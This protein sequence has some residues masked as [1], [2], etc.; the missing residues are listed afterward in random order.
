[1]ENLAAKNDKPL[2]IYDGDCGFCW[3]WASYWQKLTGD[4]VSYKPYQEVASQYPSISIKEFQQAVQYVAPDGSIASA[5]KASFLTL[6]NAPGQ[7]LWL[8]LYRKLPGFAPLTEWAYHFISTRRSFFHK[9]SIGLW[10]KTLEPAKYDMVAWIF[11]RLFGLLFLAA[12]LSFG[13]QAMALIG[14]RGIIPVAEMMKIIYQQV[15]AL[16]YWYVPVVFWLNTSDFFIQAVCWGGVVFSL[17]LI[18]NILPRAS[19]FFLYVLYLSLSYAGQVFMSFQWDMF[20]VE[21]A[22]VAIF[23]VG[24]TRLTGIMLMRWLLFR[25]I[26]AAGLVKILSGDP[27]WRNLTSLTY[28]FNTAPLPTPLAWYAHHLPVPVL[29]F[30]AFSAL[31]VELVI[32]FLIFLPRYPRFVGAFAILFMQTLISLTGNYN[33]FNLQTMLLC[34][35]LFDDQALSACLPQRFSHWLQPRA[36]CKA[37]NKWINGFA[38]V[39]AIYLIFISVVQFYQRFSGRQVPLPVAVAAGALEQ[40]RLVSVYGPFAVMTQDRMEIIFEGSA[41]GVYWAEYKFKYKPGDVDKRPPINIPHQPRVDWQMWFAA[42]GTVNQ[43][44]W[45]VRFMERILEGSPPVVDLLEYNPFPDK[46]PLL[47]RAEFYRYRFTTPEERK[48][49]GA[50]WH[51]EYVQEYV[52]AIHLLH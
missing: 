19:L 46:P 13:V 2:L 41:D 30:M 5:A 42:L 51:R 49:T 27:T 26:F 39:I 18:L 33:F 11:L 17:L 24:S 43:N 15:G 37:P 14:S 32:P 35:V 48:Q 21:A 29:K 22:I 9:I 44:P 3:Y 52:P 50:W 47:L 36:L 20:I 45:L 1:M 28:Y 6:S 34:L 8:S 40:F 16:G 23:M 10:G 38:N 12:F 7:G 4:K 31:F 25:F